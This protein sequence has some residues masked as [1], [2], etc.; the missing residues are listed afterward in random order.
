MEAVPFDKFTMT[1]ALKEGILRNEYISGG[2]YAN[3]CQKIVAYCDGFT[4]IEVDGSEREYDV[5]DFVREA[6]EKMID[7][8]SLLGPK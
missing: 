3:A 6:R 7:F 8:P 2:H 1:Y 5:E 4:F